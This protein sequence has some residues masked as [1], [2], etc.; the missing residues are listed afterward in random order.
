MLPLMTQMPARFGSENAAVRELA[1]HMEWESRQRWAPSDSE[2]E[3]AKQ[4]AKSEAMSRGEVSLW[5]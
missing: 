3:R 5:L 1:V 4:V 2:D